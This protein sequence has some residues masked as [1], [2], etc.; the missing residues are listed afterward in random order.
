MIYEDKDSEFL[1]SSCANACNID[2]DRNAR[3]RF[4]P[5]LYSIKNQRKAGKFGEMLY[6][7]ITESEKVNKNGYDVLTPEGDKVEVKTAFLNNQNHYWV[8]Q[9]YYAGDKEDVKKEW[10]HLAFVF[11]GL[12]SITIWEAE[13]PD[14]ELFAKTNSSNGREWKGKIEDIPSCFTKIAEIVL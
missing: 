8:N 2:D 10:T 5:Y 12:D 13:K 9:I 11:I 3:W 7:S 1:V 6:C 4:N 14:C